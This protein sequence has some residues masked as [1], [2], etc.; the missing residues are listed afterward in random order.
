MRIQ[1]AVVRVEGL[2]M[3]PGQAGAAVEAAMLRLAEDY[4][5]TP[6]PMRPTHIEA[7]RLTVDT[8]TNVRGEVLA[9]EI[10]RS[11]ATA[12]TRRAEADP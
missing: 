8:D 2:R 3:G 6:A 5:G 11:V 4:A 10:A 9:G 12:I 7:L 1:R